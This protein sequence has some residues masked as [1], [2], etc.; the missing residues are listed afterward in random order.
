MA[1]ARPII[2]T[3]SEA[4]CDMR[5]SYEVFNGR[6][7]PVRRCCRLHAQALVLRLSETEHSSRRS[8]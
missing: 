1:W 4:G 7:Q 6:N 2:E 5:A 3:C 8:A